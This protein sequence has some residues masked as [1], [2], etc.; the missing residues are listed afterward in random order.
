MR[1]NEG[2]DND[3][4]EYN[5]SDTNYNDTNDIDNND[6]YNVYE[7]WRNVT[8]NNDKEDKMNKTN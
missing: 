8:G 7:Q 5:N 1:V 4:H 6:D 2:N 3:D